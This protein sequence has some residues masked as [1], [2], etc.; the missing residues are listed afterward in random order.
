VFVQSVSNHLQDHVT[1]RP[2]RTVLYNVSVMSL[3]FLCTDCL[4]NV[5]LD[6]FT[7]Y[8]L[9]FLAPLVLFS[10]LVNEAP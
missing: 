6:Y 10:S 2:R 3:P 8:Q 7:C 1:S 5:S 4:P 9:S